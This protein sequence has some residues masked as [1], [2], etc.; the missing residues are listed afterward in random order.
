MSLHR[1][2]AALGLLLLA[3]SSTTS[4]A[5]PQARIMRSIDSRQMTRLADG[6][7][8]LAE[9]E[10]DQGA[11]DPS[12]MLT[13]VTMFFSRTPMQQQAL[14][15]LLQEQQDPASPKYHQWLTPEQFAAQFGM[16]QSD[17]A[18][19]QQWLESQGFTVESVARG[20]DFITFSGSVGEVNAAFRTEM[21]QYNVNGELH[22]ANA[23]APAVPSAISGVVVGF[24]GLN[25]FKP[26]ARV[27]TRKVNPRLTS[28]LSGNHFMVPDD[29]Q[30]IY[31][32]K[33]V[34]NNL[35]LDGTGQSI[36]VI[37]QVGASQTLL[38]D[39]ATFRSLSGLPS[40]TVQVVGSSTGNNSGDLGES[41]LD[42]EWAGATA[43][44]AKIVFV[45]SGDAFTSLTNAIDGNVAPVISISY[46]L[47]EQAEGNPA[48]EENELLKAAS[49]G[50]SV[51][52][53]SGDNGAADC[54]YSTTT[55]ITTSTKG[56]YV[57]FPA[58]SPYVTGIGGTTFSDKTGTYWG[59][60]NNQLNGSALGYIP[61]VVWNDTSSTVGLSATGGGVS[62][63]FPKPSWQTG[64]GVPNDGFRDVPDIS[65][66]GSPGHDQYITCSAGSCQVCYAGSAIDT[67]DAVT[68]PGTGSPDANCPS[69]TSPGYRSKADNTFNVVGG[70]SAGVP[71]FAGVV[72]LLNQ[73]AGTSQGALNQ[74]LY[75]LFASSARAYVYHDIT[76]GDNIVPCTPLTP[77]T[78][79]AAQQCP[80]TPTVACPPGAASCFGYTATA[81]YD[82]TTGLGSVDAY[83]LITNWSS[84]GAGAA[85]F[86]ILGN[87]PLVVTHGS[88]ASIPL[89]LQSLNGF[90]SSV[91]LSCT[92]NIPGVVGVTCSVPPSATP[93]LVN[94]TLT[95][96]AV[97]AQERRA[98][99]PFV[100]YWQYSFG[101]AAIFMVGKKRSKRQ[102]AAIAVVAVILIV[103]MPSCGGGGG[104]SNSNVVT[105]PN[106]GLSPSTLTFNYET[107]NATPAPQSIAVSS[108]GTAL[109][110][111]V[112][113]STN[114]GGNWLAATPTSGT[115][116]SS[117]SVSVNPA[118][119]ASG[120]YTGSVKVAAS[121]A[122]NSPQTATV[123]LNV[124]NPPFSVSP[125]GW[126]F[127]YALGGS[128]P[129]P[130]N[131]SVTS[132]QANTTYTV[133]TSTTSGGNW[134]SVTPTSGTT[135]GT[136]VVSVNPSGLTVGTYSGSATFTPSAGTPQTLLVS[137]NVTA[138]GTVTIQAT[139]GALSHTVQLPVTVN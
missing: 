109:S 91:T 29:F 40:T 90:N 127:N 110:Y 5:A 31:N 47:C 48:T 88:V 21:H 36:A 124:T 79:P 87:A 1:P 30:T 137:F 54:D 2:F 117:V 83:N 106:L 9:P 4:W 97:I 12:Q 15:R 51:I 123:T 37:G 92:V 96:P 75:Q 59:D 23:I 69:T 136:Q 122:A 95:A 129:A 77:S 103:A 38:N 50:Q 18:K 55:T 114:S 25:D 49:Q 53:P 120:T 105:T 16:A 99:S 26:R 93:G 84:P 139:S 42:L 60:T 100:P 128:A 119:L 86:A 94:V 81:G 6:V 102:I 66:A 78:A 73:Q 133:A 57:D 98:P 13:H 104:G 68:S 131:V 112:T 71:T 82:Q 76:S 33:S 72:A 74:K 101:L 34:Y 28:G 115:S 10:F 111:S 17:L 20:G 35:A 39:V 85:D 135:T 65:F 46:G 32:L 3:V 113:T 80:S 89:T 58:S 63:L 61:E 11:L 64:T 116:G 45:T 130:Q 62:I 108:S 19:V 134:L 118:G 24:R 70:T 43:P 41:A 67:T 8:P 52:G 44:G 125:S 107:G 121:G 56:L 22:F 27:K 132:S 126:S 7:H 14:D 138:V